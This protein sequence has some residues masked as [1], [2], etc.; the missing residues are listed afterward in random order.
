MTNYPDDC[1]GSGDHLPWNK[2]DDVDV[3]K[4]C[5]KAIPEDDEFSDMCNECVGGN[6]DEEND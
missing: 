3:C 6:D 1:Q 5:D 4:F 2:P